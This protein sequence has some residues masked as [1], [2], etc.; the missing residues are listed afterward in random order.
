VSV[1]ASI[2]FQAK[3]NWPRVRQECHELLR[4]T[5]SAITELTGLEP[6]C[7]DS[8]E[9]YA[10]MATVPLSPCDA[11][12]LKRRL[13]DDYRVEVP[14]ITWGGRQFVRVSAQGYNTEADVEALV[15]ALEALL[16]ESGRCEGAGAGTFQL[17]T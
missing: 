16:S 12:E 5:R 7:P 11:E 8:P 2:E 17:T 10:Q 4:Y 3:Y 1:P 15:A 9:W 6:I 14:I 13:Y